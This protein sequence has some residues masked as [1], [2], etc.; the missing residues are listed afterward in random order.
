MR[1][2]YFIDFSI[3]VKIII[4]FLIFFYMSNNTSPLNKHPIHLFFSPPK[5]PSSILKVRENNFVLDCT[6]PKYSKLQKYQSQ[7]DHFNQSYLSNLFGRL[8]T[9]KENRMPRLP[10]TVESE[11]GP[12]M[13]KT[14]SSGDFKKFLS[15]KL[16]SVAQTKARNKADEPQ[17]YL[18]LTLN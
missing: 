9:S 7:E 12:R 13:E 5:P 6:N 18:N 11:Q 17:S 2:Y 8:K 16:Y 15:E 3:Y 10:R 1:F 14:I 4:N